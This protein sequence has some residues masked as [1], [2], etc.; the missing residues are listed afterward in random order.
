MAD[1][2]VLCPSCGFKNAPG[3]KRCVSC[4]AKIQ[5]L[6]TVERS[7]REQLERRYQQE[8]FSVPW[9]MISLAVNGLL[10]GAVIL[11]L[12]AVVSTLDFEGSHGMLAS[13]L[14][15]FV[16]GILV[17]IISP[18][19]TFIEPVIASF[20]IGIPTVLYLY[21]SETVFTLPPFLYI[22][23]G[24]IGVLFT[25]IGSYIGERIQLGPAPKETD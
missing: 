18:G 14:V 20:I 7:K 4:G 10:T 9:L 19:R 6:G 12:P 3:T 15:W 2:Q 13:I 1:K 22:I 25:L 17:G 24:A 16:T 21:R 5:E 23:L 8:V 11:G